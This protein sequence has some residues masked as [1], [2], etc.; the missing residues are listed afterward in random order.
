MRKRATPPAIE[1]PD[2]AP[3]ATEE[4][5]LGLGVLGALAGACIGAVAM[6]GF[7]VLA[8]FRFPLLGVGIGAL[9]GYGAKRLYKGTG[10]ELGIICGTVSL[11]AVLGTLYTMYGTFPIMSMIS[12]AVS[13]SVA[14]RIA[15]R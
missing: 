4:L 6:Y 13:V 14:Y 2:Q 5:N 8:G 15:S 12:A 9:T 3:V 7:Y 10:N 11:V 1:I